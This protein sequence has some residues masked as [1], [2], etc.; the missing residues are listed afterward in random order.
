TATVPLKG[1][2]MLH[3]VQKTRYPWEGKVEVYVSEL[4]DNDGAPTSRALDLHLRVPG[5]CKEGWSVKL[6]GAKQDLRAEKGYVRLSRTWKG[7]DAV[8]LELPMPVERVY[9][10]PKVK[11]N[12]GRVA[13]QRGPVVYCLEGVDNG[14]KVRNLV[15]PRSAKVSAG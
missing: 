14:G 5:W 12:V 11:A 15:L 4:L 9:A 6:K 2:A 8:E 7:G 1:G 13:L 3:L 10:D